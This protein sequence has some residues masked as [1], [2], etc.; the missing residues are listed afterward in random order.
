M[1]ETADNVKNDA[2]S[3]RFNKTIIN[4]SKEARKEIA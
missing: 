4:K 3:T 1:K 2:E